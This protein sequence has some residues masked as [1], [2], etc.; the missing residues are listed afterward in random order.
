MPR[1]ASQT[2]AAIPLETEGG[3]MSDI[4]GRLAAIERKA[5]NEA[6]PVVVLFGDDIPAPDTTD[7]GPTPLIIR[8]DEEDRTL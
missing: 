2:G 7:G 3:D 5:S 6:R 8:F 4:S 1:A